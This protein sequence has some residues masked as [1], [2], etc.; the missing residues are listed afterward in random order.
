MVELYD[1]I[2]RVRGSGLLLR[3]EGFDDPAQAVRAVDELGQFREPAKAIIVWL[4]LHGRDTDAAEA[5]DAM[6][7]LR[8]TAR[9]YDAGE[10]QSLFSERSDEY[11]DPLDQ[12]IEAASRAA[13]RLED[14]DG[15][16]PHTLWRGFGDA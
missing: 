4:E 9:Q 6:A 2:G 7:G 16:I 1:W 5:D 3:R 13:G 12:L 8:E 15:T 14:L 11:F 10:L